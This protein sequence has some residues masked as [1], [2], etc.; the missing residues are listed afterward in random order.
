MTLSTAARLKP[1]IRLAQAISEFE[2]SLSTEGKA[3]FCN[4]RALT[5][6][7]T[8]DT[9]SLMCLT[10]EMDQRITGKVGRCLGLRFTSFLQCIQQF[11][12]LGDVVVGGS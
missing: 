9:T 4:Q 8:P 7:S 6:Q 1:E 10:A 11:A 2:A 3:N 12:A 5:L